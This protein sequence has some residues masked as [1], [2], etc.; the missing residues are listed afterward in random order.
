MWGKRAKKWTEAREC[1]IETSGRKLKDHTGNCEL[2]LVCGIKYNFHIPQSM[3]QKQYLIIITTPNLCWLWTL[4]L[5][6]NMNYA[7]SSLLQSYKIS[8]FIIPTWLWGNWGL[9]RL[10]N[11]PVS[12]RKWLTQDAYANQLVSKV[13]TTRKKKKKKPSNEKQKEAGKNQSLSEFSSFL[14]APILFK[15]TLHCMVLEIDLSYIL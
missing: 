3:G 1:H 8:T 10:N 14:Q 7:I 5:A 13:Y 9:Q 11:C 12:A 2:N 4:C 6:H 15:K